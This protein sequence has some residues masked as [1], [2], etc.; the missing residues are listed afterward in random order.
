MAMNHETEQGKSITGNYRSTTRPGNFHP[1]TS[2]VSALALF[3]F[4]SFFMA[5]H[6]D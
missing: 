2:F 1:I 4:F 6:V 5:M 3:V